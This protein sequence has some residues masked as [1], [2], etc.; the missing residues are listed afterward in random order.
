MPKKHK[1]EKPEI[2][3]I[4]E[5]QVFLDDGQRFIYRVDSAEQAHEHTLAIAT[6][7]YRN[8]MPGMIEHYPA[9][10]I[11]KVKAFGADLNA[12]PAVIKC[13]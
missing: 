2:K 5:I 11:S 13:A 12:S 6:T 3:K 8:C 9:H 7:G 1:Q 10:R 4:Y